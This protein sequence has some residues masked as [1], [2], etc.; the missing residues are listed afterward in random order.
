M[1]RLGILGGTFDPIHCGHVVL[2]VAA[3]EQLTLDRVLFVVAADPPHKDH[4]NDMAAAQDRWRMVELALAGTDG[5][6]ASRIELDRPGKSYTVDTLRQLHRQEPGAEI[7]LI[8]GRDNVSDMATWQDPEGILA[9]C[10]VAAGSRLTPDKSAGQAGAPGSTLP[11][12][13]SR[14]VLLDTPVIE[15]SSTLIRQRLRA[16]RTIHCMV[17]DAV[18][19]HIAGTGLYAT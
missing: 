6:E 7:F 1:P 13:A 2:A 5:L 9:L 12:L 15:L 11:D 17:P 18:E 14:V 4:R 16:R 3:R 10:T 19:R 8:I